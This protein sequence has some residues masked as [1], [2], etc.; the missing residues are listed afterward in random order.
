MNIKITGERIRITST[1]SSD[2]D[3]IIEFEESNKQFVHQYTKEKHKA[4]LTDND[5]MHLSIER[6][7]NDRLIGHMI[8]FGV[9]NFNKVL[10]F[11]RITIIEKRSGFGREA[12]KLLKQIC[13]QKLRF[14][15]LWLDV[16]E[17]NTIA[18]KLYESEG[19]IKEGLL[20]ENIMT[21]G[22]YRSQYIYSMLDNEYEAGI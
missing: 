10:E 19:F 20:R 12:I 2:I 9:K 3:R 1:I 11:R 4:L 18:I 15:R 7:D 6:K 8:L 17:D 14:H 13:F 21:D 22:G 16:Y 5:C